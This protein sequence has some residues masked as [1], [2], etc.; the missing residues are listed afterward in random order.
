MVKLPCGKPTLL[1]NTRHSATARSNSE[2]WSF[3]GN[4]GSAT[5]YLPL[6]RTAIFWLYVSDE[7]SAGLQQKMI[8][9]KT[10]KIRVFFKFLN[11]AGRTFRYEIHF[12]SVYA[13]RVSQEQRSLKCNFDKYR[14]SYAQIV[15]KL[16]FQSFNVTLTF[17]A[18]SLLPFPGTAWEGTL[19]FDQL[20]QKAR[21]TY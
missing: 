2:K 18:S 10:K 8:T 1:E 15:V 21:Y 4:K 14:N 19:T 6:I 11:Q 7:S 9:G 12:C 20:R 5:L 16:W 13:Y 17:Y 3:L